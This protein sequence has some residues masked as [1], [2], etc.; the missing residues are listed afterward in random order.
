MFRNAGKDPVYTQIEEVQRLQDELRKQIEDLPNEKAK[1]DKLRQVVLDQAGTIDERLEQ[2]KKLE[3]APLDG[4]WK[5]FDQ[6]FENVARLTRP[7]DPNYDLG[8]ARQAIAHLLCNLSS[9]TAH[10]QRAMVVVGLRPYIH[11]VEIQ[12]ANLR[13]MANRLRSMMVSDRT[14]FESEYGQ[15][16]LRLGGLTET[17]DQMSMA[18]KAKQELVE[19]GRV[20]YNKRVDDKANLEAKVNEMKVD[21]G[22]ALS[23]QRGLEKS[24]F[25]L[26]AELGQIKEQTEVLE[27]ELR[28]LERAGGR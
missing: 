6:V 14:Q 15:L 25:H 19:L 17:I 10:Q 13:D 4:W 2:A 27:E 9:D 26:N 23:A 28:R 8:K 21:R 18:V 20:D 1:K 12:A 24:L 3:D 5:A 16:L 11:E 7:D 22:K